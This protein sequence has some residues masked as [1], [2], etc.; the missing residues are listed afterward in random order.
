LP[1]V[2]SL[3][4]SFAI[5]TRK[6]CFASAPLKSTTLICETSNIP[7][8]QD[9]TDYRMVINAGT[10]EKDIAWINTQAQGFDVR[11]E[12]KFDLAMIAVQGPNSP[13]KLAALKGFN[14]P[15]IPSVPGI[16]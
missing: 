16:A 15:Q 3:S 11:V 13:P 1:L 2:L 9:D 7:A 10:T 14:S 5:N 12:P 6:N 8:Y 4:T